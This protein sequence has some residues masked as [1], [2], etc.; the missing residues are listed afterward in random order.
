MNAERV[1]TE[2]LILVAGATGGV[3]QLVVGKLWERGLKVRI[4]TRNAAKAEK[5]FD[6]IE[7]AVGDILE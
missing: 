1:S 5:M 7:V 6:G 3:G 2:D 4:L